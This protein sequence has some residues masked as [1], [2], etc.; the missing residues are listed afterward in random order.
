MRN[1]IFF[2]TA[3]TSALMLG[4]CNDGAAPS[5]EANMSAGN[6]VELGQTQPVNEAQDAAGAAVG[7][8]SAA[9]ANTADAYVPNAAIGDMYEIESSRLAVEKSQSAGV[10]AF[11]QQM[12]T[13]HTATTAKL[14]ETLASA[15][16]AITPP[17]ALDARRQGMIDN[18][19]AASAADFDKTYLDQQTAAH[20]EAVTLHS[21]YAEDGENPALK[22]LA[23]ATTPKIQHHL[24]MVQKLDQ[25][26]ADGAR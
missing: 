4:A 19:K 16:L 10:K 24:E 20:R 2:V 26:G 12:I 21:G 7:L 6:T 15:N 17:T 13:D 25:G 11:A 18:L 1:R 8:G 5:A 9:A 22:Q 3:A 23:A 14:K